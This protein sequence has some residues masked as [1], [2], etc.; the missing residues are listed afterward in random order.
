VNPC[1]HSR[2]PKPCDRLTPNDPQFERGPRGEQFLIVN[3]TA[4]QR[5]GSE[6]SKI[7]FHGGERRRIDNGSNDRYWCCSHCKHKRYLNISE[8]GG[9]ATS[10]AVRHLKNHHHLD[11]DVDEQAIRVRPTS[12]FSSV[13]TAATATVATGL[14]QA[15]ASTVRTAKALISTIDMIRFRYLLIRWIVMMNICLAVVEH[16]DDLLPR[17]PCSVPCEVGYHNQEV[18]SEGVQEIE[19]GNQRRISRRSLEDSYLCRP[20]DFTQL[21]RHCRNRCP[22]LD[23][24]LKV[25]SHLIGMR[26]VYGAHSGENIAEAMIPVLQDFDIAPR[27]GYFIGDNHGSN[28]TCLRAICRKLRPDIKDPDARRVRCL[29]LF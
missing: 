17:R 19:A 13:A 24:N 22:F 25:Q 4:N 18:D 29:G 1:S 14:S 26:R 12:L 21:P 6:V 2:S 3:H 8:A 11:I 9:G 15:A 27:L 28:D 5:N 20:L 10:H 16:D 23:K 7:W